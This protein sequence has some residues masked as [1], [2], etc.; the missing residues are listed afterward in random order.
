M[1]ELRSSFA[2]LLGLGVLT[3]SVHADA[4]DR[5]VTTREGFEQAVRAS[6][7][8]DAVVLADGVW[9][10][11][12]IVFTGEGTADKPITLRAQ[13]AGKVVISGLSNLRLS[14]RYLIVSG[15]TFKD[16]HSPSSEVISFRRDSKALAN[17]SRVTQVVVDGFNNPDRGAGDYWIGLYGRNNRIDHSHL[18][19]KLSSGVTLAVVLNGPESQRNNHRIDHNYFGPRPPLG[20]NGG[21]TIRVGTSQFSRI[22]SLTVV[23]DN[24]FEGCSGEV[25]IVSN[26]SGGNIYRRNVF[27]RSQGALVLR[28]GD[29]NL[30]EDNV[31]LGQGVPHT[32]GVRVINANQTVRDNYFQGLAGSDFTSAL[33]M[34]NGVPNSP[35]N[36]YNQVLNARIENNVFVDVNEVLF[37]AGADQERTLPPA[38]SVLAGNVFLG[39]GERT[40]FKAV[41]PVDGLTFDANIVD[42]VAPPAG[43]AGFEARAIGR[44]T[45]PDGRIYPDAAARKALGLNEPVKLLSRDETGVAW[46]PKGDQTVAFD[47]GRVLRIK[48]GQD[49]LSAA[50]VKARAGDVIELATGAYAESQVIKVVAPLTVRA[51]KGAQP[52]MTFDRSTLFSLV[53]RGAL[54]LQGLR[55]SGAKAPDADGN[56]LIRVSPSY[57]LNNYAVEMI[58]TEVSDMT[59]KTFAV[60][61]GE[62]NTFADHVRITGSRFADINGSVLSIAGETENL[63]LYGVETVDIT[64]SQ[65]SRLGA[66]ALD[67]LRGGADES[68]FG[69]R[70]RISRSTFTDIAPGRPSMSLDGAQVVRLETSTFERAGPVRVTIHVGKPDLGEAGNAGGAL[71]IIDQRK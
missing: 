65:F 17:D 23:E 4:A 46:Y 48:P 7:P 45:L 9:R 60:L 52:V 29:G 35:L 6:L 34:M 56:A 10:D 62:K 26:K 38:Q 54:K 31:F 57:P 59:N 13:T 66:P 28:H 18:Q 58:D 12:Q 3:G 2:A 40:I 32:G 51:G 16:G 27:L 22:D 47:S 55:L 30:V 64:N 37:G 11:F 70:V 50:A 53:G 21:E 39:S 15:L 24:Y 14:G 8:G 41:A 43:V 33:V 25:E 49:Q 19:G 36:R 69:P 44:E 1:R 71:E 63:G 68:T 5:L 42:G 67:I 20:A 61:E